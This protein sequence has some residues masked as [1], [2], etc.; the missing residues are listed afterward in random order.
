MHHAKMC[1][2]FPPI[3]RKWYRP[4]KGIKQKQAYL[5]WIDCNMCDLQVKYRKTYRRS[6]LALSMWARLTIRYILRTICQANLKQLAA[7]AIL[8]DQLREHVLSY[9]A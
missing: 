7:T 4:M 6:A 1:C 5:Q 9:A 2:A 8:D 3:I